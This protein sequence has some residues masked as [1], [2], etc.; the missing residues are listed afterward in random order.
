VAVVEGVQH[1]TVFLGQVLPRLFHVR[2][3]RPLEEAEG[4]AQS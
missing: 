2:L 1:Q 4:R 3:E